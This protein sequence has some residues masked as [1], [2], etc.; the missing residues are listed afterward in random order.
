MKYLLLILLF[1]SCGKSYDQKQTGDP[2]F[3]QYKEAFIETLENYSNII[4]EYDKIRIRNI[5]IQFKELEEGKA[6]T[7]I[8]KNLILISPKY[9]NSDRYL[10]RL[11]FHELA[12]CIYNLKHIQDQYDLMHPNLTLLPFNNNW[13]HRIE[14][15]TY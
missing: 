9:K 6:G 3:N 1:I 4:T 11:V 10:N 13:I 14:I 8:N 12:H 7:C 2:F 5:N 15:G